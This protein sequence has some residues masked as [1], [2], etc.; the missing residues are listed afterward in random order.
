MY[1]KGVLGAARI[2]VNYVKD[3]IKAQKRLRCYLIDMYCK[4]L[5]RMPIPDSDCLGDSL[6]FRSYAFN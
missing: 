5:Y 2:S 1:S 4:L 3:D 6:R